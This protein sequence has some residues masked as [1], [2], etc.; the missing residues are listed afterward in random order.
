MFRISSE[1][2]SS[3]IHDLILLYDICPRDTF[4]NVHIKYVP[5]TQICI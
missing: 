2:Y 5:R 1:I 4:I 3:H